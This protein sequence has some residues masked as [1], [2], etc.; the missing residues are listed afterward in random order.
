M[1]RCGLLLLRLAIEYVARTHLGESGDLTGL[2]ARLKRIIPKPDRISIDQRTFLIF[3]LAQILGWYPDEL[4]RLSRSEWTQLVEEVEAFS[5]LERRR[6]YHLAFERRYRNQT[7]D[8]MIA[9][10][11]PHEAADVKSRAFKFVA[12][13]TSARNRSGGIWRKS[14]RSARPMPSPAF[15]RSRCIT[16]GRPMRITCRC[17]RS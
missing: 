13:S 4:N 7:L 5:S 2:R 15:M 1:W 3:Q 16:A 11:P 14:T 8:A 6:I 9:H 17:A 12:A 10:A